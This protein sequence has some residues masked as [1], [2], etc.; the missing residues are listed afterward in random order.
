MT[1]AIDIPAAERRHLRSRALQILTDRRE[2]IARAEHR[3]AAMLKGWALEM[4]GQARAI[5][6]AS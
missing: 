3:T 5:Q 4:L 1:N 2:A 6:A